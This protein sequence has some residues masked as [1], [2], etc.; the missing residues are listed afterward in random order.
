M[1]SFYNSLMT[2]AAQATEWTE[3]DVDRIGLA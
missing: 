3:G 2:S 1:F